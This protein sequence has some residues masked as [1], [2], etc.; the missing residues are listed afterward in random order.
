MWWAVYQESHNITSCKTEREQEFLQ[1]DNHRPQ[2]NHTLRTWT[3]LQCDFDSPVWLR[4]PVSKQPAQ[5]VCL[6]CQ[7]SFCYL[8]HETRLLLICN[9][10]IAALQSVMKS[11]LIESSTCFKKGFIVCLIRTCFHISSE[12]QFN[13]SKTFSLTQIGGILS[14]DK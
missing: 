6:I 9:Y 14:L 7:K 3:F 1:Q 4:L 11:H 2:F 10:F 5:E 13:I 12:R 8:L